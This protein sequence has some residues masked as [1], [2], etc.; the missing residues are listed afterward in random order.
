MSTITRARTLVVLGILTVG[1]VAAAGC[2]REA[3]QLAG[4]GGYGGYDDAFGFDFGFG[5]YDT[6]GCYDC[7]YDDSYY[8]DVYYYDDPGWWW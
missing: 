7:Y 6:G 2:D 3:L 1:L 8:E 4:L 5:G